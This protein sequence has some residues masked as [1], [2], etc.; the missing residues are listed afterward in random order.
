MEGCEYMN[1]QTFLIKKDEVD[2]D[3]LPKTTNQHI[4]LAKAPWSYN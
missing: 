3:L 4:V 1:V 2:E